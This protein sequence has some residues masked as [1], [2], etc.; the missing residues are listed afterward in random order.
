MLGKL[1][2]HEFK[3]AGRLMFV[4][5]GV[6]AAATLLVAAVMALGR[7]Q[8]GV[9]VAFHSVAVACMAFYM[10][11]IV[12][13][14]VTAFIH[15]VV[16]FYQTMY[17]AQGYL[18]HTLPLQVTQV[19]HVKILAAGAYM[20]LT[21]SICF[22]SFFIVGSVGDGM[23]SGDLVAM[24]RQVLDET[25]AE[26]GISGTACFL[27]V[28]ALLV[29]ACVNLV[30]LLFAGLSIG[31]LANRSKSAWGIAASIGLYYLNQVVSLLFIGI[32]YLSSRVADLQLEG[33]WLPAFALCVALL[34]IAVY[35]AI[36]RT[37]LQKHL[38]L[39]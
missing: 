15:L 39:E 38:N 24:I 34:W 7:S 11:T 10:I 37:V 19:L 23:T 12:V 3:D 5:Y 6:I 35:Y 36:S 1:M 33:K 27:Y 22:L 16:R 20:V 17:T 29:L 25:G 31:Q 8:G 9:G 21:V 32:A 26:V 30:L 28:C 13:L 2:K 4:I 18:T 14:L